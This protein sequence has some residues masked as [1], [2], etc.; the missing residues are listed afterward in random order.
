VKIQRPSRTLYKFFIKN[1]FYSI[2]EFMTG[3]CYEEELSFSGR[4]DHE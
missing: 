2:N 3:N 4:K 1:A